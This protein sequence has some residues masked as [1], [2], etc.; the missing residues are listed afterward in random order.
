MLTSFSKVDFKTLLHECPSL[1]ILPGCSSDAL[2]MY[3]M[4]MRTARS[5]A[6]IANYFN[7]SIATISTK[8]ATVR[9]A[10]L[11][12]IVPLY[13]NFERSREEILSHT[14]TFSRTFFDQNYGRAH[15]ILDGTYVYI[16]SSKDHSFQKRTYNSHKKRNYIKMMMGTA[17][18]GEILFALG[19]YQATENDASITDKLLE[20]DIPAL[21]SYQ[22]G[23]VIIV[24]RG[25][26]D[27]QVNL[28]NRGFEVK[29][30]ACSVSPQLTCREA[31]KS[32]LVTKVRYDIERLNGVMKNTWKIFGTTIETYWIPHIATDFQICSA[33][34]NR[35]HK[36][37]NALNSTQAEKD[38]FIAERMLSRVLLP[39]IVSEVVYKNS[40]ESLI[41]QKQFTHFD[42]EM[43]PELSMEDLENL[44]FG[45]YQISQAQLYLRTHLNHNDE[46]FDVFTFSSEVIDKY[47]K[48][49]VNYNPVLVM[50][51]LK[52]RFR[53]SKT[54]RSFVLF[55]ASNS[56]HEAILGYCC[57]C[58]VGL[59]TVG[60]CSHVMA[61]IFFLGYAPHNGGIKHICLHLKDVFDRNI[62][63]SESDKSI[64]SVSSD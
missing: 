6:E 41:R 4:K 62:E 14:T 52:S 9:Q 53:S 34:V 16:E 22:L 27:C 55:S 45:P 28:I 42:T 61:L 21:R 40:F 19:P 63:E 26:R 23:D 60:V 30:P 36:T 56:G 48:E 20:Q 10:L 47:F 57:Q 59:R 12:D 5:L 64:D 51:Q 35:K 33:L 44:S 13:V 49:H 17:P 43:F 15:L 2:F 1:K 39:N 29:M 54:H 37:Q 46:K 3:L 58:K 8:I 38:R 11:K 50:A 7:V 24:D 32:R 31:N 18:D 25:F